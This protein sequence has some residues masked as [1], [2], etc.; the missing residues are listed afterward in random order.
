MGIILVS[1][2][3]HQ[4]TLFINSWGCPLTEEFAV[5]FFFKLRRSQRF[6][7]GH[8]A[9]LLTLMYVGPSIGFPLLNKHSASK[10]LGEAF[11]KCNWRFAAMFQSAESIDFQSCGQGR[12]RR[13]GSLVY[14][15]IATVVV[16]FILA[17]VFISLYAVE[18]SKEAPTESPTSPPVAKLCLSRICL[19]NTHGKSFP[20]DL[21]RGLF[22]L[23]S[24]VCCLRFLYLCPKSNFR[25]DCRAHGS[26]T[27]AGFL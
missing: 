15:L 13:S 11:Q 3:L 8:K 25:P 5:L 19:D 24:Y 6:H 26:S 23:S 12:A 17:V 18:K 4:W 1:G 27:T 9:I 20:F 16:L 22:V 10:V 14:A 21:L 7:C 2:Q